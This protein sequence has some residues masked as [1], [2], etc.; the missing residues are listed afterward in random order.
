MKEEQGPPLDY[1]K[2]SGLF[3]IFSLYLMNIINIFDLIILKETAY[4][5]LIKV[6]TSQTHMIYRE[7]QRRIRFIDKFI[8]HPMNDRP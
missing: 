7:P 2:A 4:S 1:T 5:K 3:T 8:K 6:D